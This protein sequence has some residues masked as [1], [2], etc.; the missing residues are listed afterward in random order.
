[1]SGT[2]VWVCVGLLSGLG[3]AATASERTAALVDGYTRGFTV[4]G[5]LMLGAAVLV[6]S[7]IRRRDVAA[8]VAS[9]EPA[10]ASA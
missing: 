2:A 9:E 7:L 1:M 4:G 5:V 10:L 8:I 3:H 6:V